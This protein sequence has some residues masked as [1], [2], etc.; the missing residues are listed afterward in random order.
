MLR[1]VIVFFFSLVVLS[2]NGQTF[3]DAERNYLNGKNER[4]LEQVNTLIQEHSRAEYLLLRAMINQQLELNSNAYDDYVTALSLDQDYYEA[5]FQ[6]GEFLMKTADYKRAVASFSYLLNRLKKGETKG[7]FFK[8]D[9]YAREGVKVTSLVSMEP[10][11]LMNRAMAFHALGEYGLALQDFSQAIQLDPTT[12]KYVNRALLLADMGKVESARSDLKK[13]IDLNPSSALA[14]YNL[15]VLDHTTQ[16]PAQI[17]DS[18]FGP[19][20]SMKGVEAYEQGENQKAKVYFDQALKLMPE[21]VLLLVN[22][23]RLDY[24]L[25]D[26]DAAE[27]KFL[28][29][30]KLDEKR[31]ETYYLLGNVHFARG[32][33]KQALDLYENYLRTDPTYANIWFNAGMA[34]LELKQVESACDC[35]ERAQDLG[36]SKA[37]AFLS[38]HCTKE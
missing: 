4:A 14:W 23:G 29:A 20:L 2:G 18:E 3:E 19:L 25:G 35:L 11:L 28:K 37:S 13:A 6:F 26:M 9:V 5:Y 36:M 32:D 30:R 10:E 33:F 16:L 8:R 15:L 21:D 17:E 34:Y 22:A 27:K 38:T 31:T 7:I 1:L 24:R 12:D